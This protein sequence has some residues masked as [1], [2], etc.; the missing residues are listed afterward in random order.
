MQ[1]IQMNIQRIIRK[2]DQDITSWIGN[3]A[4]AFTFNGEK[5]KIIPGI[6]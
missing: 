6:T 4:A 5:N 3:V 2:V 1:T